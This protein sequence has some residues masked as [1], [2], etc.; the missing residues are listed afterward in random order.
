MK[1]GKVLMNIINALFVLGVIYLCTN[2]MLWIRLPWVDLSLQISFQHL[3]I[4]IILTQGLKYALEIKF[5]FI[6]Q[7]KN[8]RATKILYYITI[9]FVTLAILMDYVFL[10]LETMM[11]FLSMVSLVIAFF[12]SILLP[13]S[14]DRPDSSPEILDDV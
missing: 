8:V 13:S 10:P 11:L 5:N 12:L 1:S 7:F 4:Y 6:D 14:D 3:I 2:I 9:G